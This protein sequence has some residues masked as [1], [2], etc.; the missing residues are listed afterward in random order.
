VPISVDDQFRTR[1][2]VALTVT[3]PGV[4][5]NDDLAGAGQ[6]EVRREGDVTHGMLTLQANGAFTYLPDAGFV[7]EDHFAYRVHAGEAASERATVTL[8]VAEDAPDEGPGEDPDEEPDDEE[9]N[10]EEPNDE[11]GAS[12]HI[13]FPQ[14]AR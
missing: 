6:I 7:G 12:H 1:P 4:L 11:P 9:P 8:V 2:G 13:F 5:E 10:D 14:V 3:V